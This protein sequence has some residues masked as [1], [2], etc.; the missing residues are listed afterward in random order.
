MLRILENIVA[1]EL[2]RRGIETYYFKDRKECD[3]IIKQGQSP[4]HAIQVCWELTNRNEKREIAGL[5]D[6]CNTLGLTSG[7]IL[8][9]VEEE[10]REEDGLKISVLPVWKWL[11]ETDV[12]EIL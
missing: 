11:L 4:T 3:F 1:I 5:R 8:T 10:E 9:Y 6:A 2:F 12:T 7:I